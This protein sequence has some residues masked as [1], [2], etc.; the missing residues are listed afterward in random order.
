M[1]YFLVFYLLVTVCG[2]ETGWFLLD[3]A[4]S[5]RKKLSVD[6]LG[7]S[8]LQWRQYECTSPFPNGNLHFFFLPHWFSQ[9]LHGKYFQWW[10]WA[11]LAPPHVTGNVIFNALHA[12]V[13]NRHRPTHCFL[14]GSYRKRSTDTIVKRCF[15]REVLC[16][17]V[18]SNQS[19]CYRKMGW[20]NLIHFFLLSSRRPKIKKMLIVH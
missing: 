15:I 5:L 1:G 9:Y 12:G 10:E 16:E 19:S 18:L 11:T 13:R 3:S 4:C 14:I 17:T 2:R 8:R 7:V 20:I 6:S